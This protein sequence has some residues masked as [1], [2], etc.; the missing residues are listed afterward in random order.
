MHPDVA[1]RDAKAMIDG[2]REVEDGDYAVLIDDDI[3]GG[4]RYYKRQGGLWILDTNIS[5]KAFGDDQK[6][7]CNLSEKCLAI[8]D[9]CVDLKAA[10]S[11]L[12]SENVSQV[13][14]EF[15][16]D[17]AQGA[18]EIA[19][20]TS[21]GMQDALRR[22]S[23]L[24]E[25]RTASSLRYDRQRIRLGQDIETIETIRS[26]HDK[27][28]DL[29]LGQSD[30]AKR[31]ADIGRFISYY[32]RSANDGEDSY[33]LY[34]ISTDAKLLPS[35]LSQLATA[36]NEQSDYLQTLRDICREQGTISDDGDAWVDKHS[37]YTIMAI[38]FDDEEGFRG[39]ET[40]HGSLP[41]TQHPRG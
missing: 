4:F 23:A 27:L 12:Q 24:R 5:D 7:F 17:L 19:A 3:E 22:I 6:F 18:S 28:R 2:H 10:K 21:Q 13:L 25:M 41:L 20:E 33:W 32:T 14:N 34:C 38:D 8:K 26:P 9:D 15:D 37:G 30:L 36:F 35:F 39:W 31:Q 40:I 11:E 29:I 16:S 1:Q